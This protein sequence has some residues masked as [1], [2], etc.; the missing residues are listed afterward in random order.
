M[1]N[2]SAENEKN[3]IENERCRLANGKATDGDQNDE[4]PDSTP[5]P[6]EIDGQRRNQDNVE[7]DDHP[8]EP[9]A[10]RDVI[11]NTSDKANRDVIPNVN[12]QASLHT[13]RAENIEENRAEEQDQRIKQYRE[14][15]NRL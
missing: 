5:V 9:T 13:V 15:I 3:R 1:R 4:N 10:D 8:N 2:Q 6:D 11:P 12:E 14:E 7:H